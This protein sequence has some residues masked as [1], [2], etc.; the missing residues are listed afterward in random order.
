[1]ENFNFIQLDPRKKKEEQ[2]QID[3]GIEDTLGVAKTNIDHHGENDTAETPSACEQMLT[4]ENLPDAETIATV[5]PDADSV[6]A[7]AIY[8]SRK[9]GKNINTDLV[10]KIGGVDRLGPQVLGKSWSPE[11][12]L[13]PETQERSLDEK[14]VVAIARLASDFRKQLVDRVQTVQKILG[15]T[16]DEETSSLVEKLV[17]ERDKDFAEA[18]K[19]SEIK[20]IIPGKLVLVKSTHR[21]ATNIGYQYAPTVVAFNPEMAV[22]QKTA[23]GKFAPT[24]EKYAKFTIC[25]YDSNVKTDLVSALKEIQNLEEGWGGR[26][27]IFGSPQNKSS[28]LT[29]EQITEIIS[30]YVK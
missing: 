25:R 12:S 8:A 20:E 3:L 27:D 9:Q 4:L 24:G 19:A 22:M 28:V 30:K 2:P 6:T 11:A 1:M 29:P 13:N 14:I 18:L 21:F 26:G 16:L 7:M 17:S 15:G 5:R 23:D 10:K